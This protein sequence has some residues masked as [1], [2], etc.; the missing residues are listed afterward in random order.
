[1][2]R[3]LL[4]WFVTSTAFLLVYMALNVMFVPPLPTKPADKPGDAA[5]GLVA[6]ADVV[7]AAPLPGASQ[8]P[9]GDDDNDDPEAEPTET[10]AP[11][12]IT[13]GSMDAASG[14]HMLAT[15]N[16]RGGTIERIELT[17]RDEKGR[18]KYRRVD[19]TSGYLGYLAP[20][21]SAASDGCLVRVV[22]PGTPAALAKAQSADVAAGLMP[23][24]L[25]V[26]VNAKALS[27]PT[28]LDRLLSK[29]KPGDE[30]AIEVLRPQASATED[31]DQAAD[32]QPPAPQS[33]TFNATLTEHPLDLIRLASNGGDDEVPGNLSRLACRLTL[34]QLGNKSIQTGKSSIEGLEWLSEA[35]YRHEVKGDGGEQITFSL[36]LTSKQL[37]GAASGPITISRSYSL[38]PGSYLIDMSVAVQNSGDQPQ[39]LA[40]R[41]E[42]PC[43]MT[44][45]GWWYSTKISPNFLGGAAAR[46]VIYKTEREGHILISGYD[47]LKKAKNSPLDPNETIFA[48]DEEETARSLNYVGIDAQYFDVAYLPPADVPA[49]KGFRRAAATLVADASEVPKHKERAADVSFFVDSVVADVPPNATLRQ[50]LRMFAG[51]KVPEMLDSLGLGDTIEYGWFGAVS[52][53]LGRILHL[54]YNAIGNYAIAI[55][56]LTIIVRALLFPVSRNA[57]IHAQRMQELA[58]ELKKIN[59]KYKDDMEGKLRAQREFQKRV[60]FNPLAGCLPALLQL[61]IFIG[62]YRCLSVDIELRQAAFASSL[63][64]ASNLAGP[65]ML[66]YWRDW[67]PEFFSGRGTGWLGPYFNILPILVVI[68]FLI[69]QKMFMPPPTDEQQAITQ[70]VMTVMT[71]MMALFFFR[72]PA[73]LCVYFITSSLWG[74]AERIIVKK[75]IPP[76]KLALAGGEVIEGTVTSRAPVEKVSL[77]DRIKSQ[78]HP[79]P[80]KALPPGKRKKP[81]GRK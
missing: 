9:A 78:I 40:Y 46:D 62:L 56:L 49:F 38:A 81:P 11:A 15:F 3:R 42:G 60:G 36:P 27:G 29:T 31:N 2:E 18:L 26:A 1:M 66:Y 64:W 39:K 25:I 33:L 21:P 24:D 23:G 34:S 17:E 35:L 6:D 52:K 72:V 13:L 43:G 76:S 58:P 73:G 30:I 51:P 41:L 74:I 50:P 20:E 28:E 54:L 12:R 75:T 10:I 16:N 70:K 53:L 48:V 77:A 68:L 37:L 5:S 61:P 45:E 71:L 19:T 57:A 65:D 63:Q 59:D 8:T 80:P 4:L 22:G 44:L 69:Q 67:L 79:E 55:V 7:D 14:Y 47:L 32:A